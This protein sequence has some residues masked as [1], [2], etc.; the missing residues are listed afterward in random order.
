MK[1]PR[2]NFALTVC[3][4]LVYVFGGISAR[5]SI[6]RPTITSTICEKYDP[7][8]DKWDEHE[9]KGAFP[10]AAFGWTALPP[11]DNKGESSRILILGGTDGNLIQEDQYIVDFKAQKC[12]VF[13]NTIDQQLAMSKLVCRDN[14][15][16]CIAGFNSVGVNY[17]RGLDEG[18]E[19]KEFQRKHSSILTNG[20]N[21]ELAHSSFL[22]F[23]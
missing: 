9:I 1:S 11:Y 16:Y 23:E 7:N 21:L 12:D 3:E 4:N 22:Y 8:T 15:L 17:E 14:K 19:W 18:S 10:L 13:A 2:A 6:H 20:A 5:E